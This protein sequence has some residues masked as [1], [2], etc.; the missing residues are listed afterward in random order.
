MNGTDNDSNLVL[1]TAREHYIAHWLLIKIYKNNEKLKHAFSMMCSLKDKRNFTAKQYERLK[2]IKSEIHKNKIVTE[3]TC[4]L[5]SDAIKNL[6]NN[7]KY[8]KQCI[9]SFK[10]KKLSEEHKQKIRE[11]NLGKKRSKETIEK[12]KLAQNSEE[13]K[14]KIKES[15]NRFRSKKTKQKI[16][17]SF[18][19]PEKIQ[20][21]HCGNWY[22]PRNAYRWH[23]NK[24]KSL[25][26]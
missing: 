20:C 4:K 14:Q 19:L 23:F 16:K 3:E 6:W 8:K 15:L 2:Q 25:I 12:M 22:L 10:T 26:S 24:C 21:P 5:I 11:G 7:E 1:L 18:K 9:K 13:T 17:N